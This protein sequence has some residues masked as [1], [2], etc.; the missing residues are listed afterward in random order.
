MMRFLRIAGVGPV[1]V[2]LLVSWL[3][4]EPIG[5]SPAKQRL[6]IN[7]VKIPSGSFLMGDAT[8]EGEP[9]ERPQRRVRVS[10]F[11]IARHE[12]TQAEWWEVLAWALHHGY[13]FQDDHVGRAQGPDHP[14][15][16]VSWYDALKWANA[17]S[18]KEGRRPAYY[19]DREHRTVYREGDVD[20]G[21]DQVDWAGD[22]YR[23]PT[24]AEWEK[25]ARGG[26]KGHHYP[27]PSRG[28]SYVRHVDGCRANFALSQ[29]PY[30]TERFPQT[31]PVGYFAASKG[32]SGRR[33]VQGYGLQD[34]AGNVWE[35]CWDW[36][37]FHAY[38]D[39]GK[40][41]RDPRGPSSGEGRVQRG[42]S[43]GTD[44]RLCRVAFRGLSA[45]GYR[46]NCAGFRLVLCR[47]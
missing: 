9:W 38:A 5:G 23:L 20:L 26:L 25:A 28:G 45:P 40:R 4:A 8:G 27:W 12:V 42:G 31:T 37:S 15:T 39:L 11:Y 7:F 44:P 21:P 17:R 10:A 24:E 2:A 13:S 34:V 30:E 1:A 22:G 35:W 16:E 29:D 6:P 46:C 32:R 18:E 19:V 43:W 36:W 33:F 47:P 41:S 14:I 3:A